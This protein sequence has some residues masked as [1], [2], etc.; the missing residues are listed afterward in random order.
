V[1]NQGLASDGPRS[2]PKVTHLASTGVLAAVAKGATI[3]FR[4][5]QGK[6][7]AT[8]G[9]GDGWTC[10]GDALEREA[11]RTAGLGENIRTD[12]VKERLAKAGGELV[13]TEN[14]TAIDPVGAKPK[15]TEIRFPTVK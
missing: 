12:R 6:S 4:D 3:E 10:K 15:R 11:E 7:L 2:R 8:L 5:A 9:I 14:L 1:R 13:Y